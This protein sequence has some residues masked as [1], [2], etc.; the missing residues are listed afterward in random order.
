MRSEWQEVKAL[1]GSVPLYRRARRAGATHD[2]V[3]SVLR[4]GTS[5]WRYELFRTAGA[6]HAEALRLGAEGIDA[7]SY[8]DLRHLGVSDD[9]VRDARR[10]GAPL[11]V[12]FSARKAG[13]GHDDATAMIAEGFRHAASART[14]KT[15][16]LAGRNQAT[17]ANLTLVVRRA[18]GFKGDA[19]DLADEIVA[20]GTEPA[21]AA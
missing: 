6:S 9:E 7:I 20:E 5:F 10:R 14:W 21:K 17:Q 19:E 4:D 16:V 3:V 13:L 18:P 11:D 1:G 12:Y 15:A 8:R 2:E